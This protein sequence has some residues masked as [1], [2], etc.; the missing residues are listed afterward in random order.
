MTTNT[1][2]EIFINS[3]DRGFLGNLDL[4]IH[5]YPYQGR[6]QFLR[7][8]EMERQRYEVD[9]TSEA[10]EW[11]LLTEVDNETFLNSFIE[12]VDETTLFTSW[13]SYDSELELLL[14]RMT[15]SGP[16][17]TAAEALNEEILAAISTMGLKGT[18]FKLGS[19][20]QVAPMGKKEPDK[21]WLPKR[22]P[23]GRSSEWPSVVLEVA[24]SE[25][26]KKLQSDVRYWLRASDGNVK[27]VFT[28]RIGRQ[29]PKITI[30]TWKSADEAHSRPHLQQIT[31][32]SRQT[33][34]RITV[35]ESPL[36]LGFEDLFLRPPTGAK[37]TDIELDE[38]QL[39]SIAEEI[40]ALQEFYTLSR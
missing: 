9:T 22:L 18:L 17:E 23:R 28:I 15:K 31:E 6:D 38:N 5:R 2:R 24:F 29:Q 14:V 8:F 36:V 32:I 30:E 39:Q 35:S 26:P 21:S 16:H 11:L 40:W 33:N 7:D 34:G 13:S 19:R 27:L 37:E 1:D 10:S 3:P 12:P 4:C 20:T 25:T